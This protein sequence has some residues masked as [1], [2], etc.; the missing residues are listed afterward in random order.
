VKKSPASKPTFISERQWML[1]S[2]RILA[3]A[4]PLTFSAEEQAAITSFIERG[5]EYVEEVQTELREQKESPEFKRIL[6]AMKQRIQ[7]TNERT[8]D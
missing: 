3:K 8:N 5:S 4:G 6:A 7:K 2:L 1:I